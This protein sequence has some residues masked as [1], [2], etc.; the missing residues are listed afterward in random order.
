MEQFMKKRELKRVTKMYTKEE[1][2]N[3]NDNSVDQQ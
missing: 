3:T 1:E 2:Y